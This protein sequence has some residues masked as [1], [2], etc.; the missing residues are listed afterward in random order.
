[1][2][3]FF[4]AHPKFTRVLVISAKHALNAVLTNTALATMMPSVFNFHS[5]AGLIALAKGAGAAVAAREAA[6]WIPPLLKWSQEN[7]NFSMFA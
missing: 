4:Q 5:A 6:V 3:N 2:P 1:M 7:L